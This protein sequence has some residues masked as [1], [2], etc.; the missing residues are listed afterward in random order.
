MVVVVVLYLAFIIYVI[1]IC[2]N[3]N[4]YGYSLQL[5]NNASS[6]GNFKLESSLRS[7]GEL[8]KKCVGVV[9]VIVYFLK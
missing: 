1:L 8:L 3:L 7:T 2:I 4:V 9:R 6:F 5:A